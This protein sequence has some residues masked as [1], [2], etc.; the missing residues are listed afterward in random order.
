MI[1]GSEPNS[2]DGSMGNI[3]MHPSTFR[4][5]CS[6]ILTLGVSYFLMKTCLV[7]SML[8]LFSFSILTNMSMS[9]RMM[10]NFSCGSYAN[11]NEAII[12]IGFNW[13]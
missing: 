8:D 7:S 4:F 3:V 12:F 11:N 2:T 10:Y 6:L 1:E 9:Y 13:A 5:K